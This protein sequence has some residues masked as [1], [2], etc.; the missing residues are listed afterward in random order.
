MSVRVMT[1]VWDTPLP[2]SDK[3]VLLALADCANDEGGA[4]PSMATL[5]KKCSKSDRTIQASIKRLCEA[6]HLT[7]IERPGK[8]CN[9]TVHPRS[10]FTPEAASP[11]KGATQ[12]PEAASDKPSRITIPQKATP[13][14]VARVSR[15]D[16]QSIVD[17]WNA[18][19]KPLRLPLASKL[20]A[21][22]RGRLQARIA[23]HGRDA[24]TEA[25]QR[26]ADSPHC[27]GENDRGWRAGFDFLLQPSSFLK[28]IEGNYDERK[29]SRQS[30]S[31]Y[32]PGQFR[33]PVLA[34]I[35]AMAGRQ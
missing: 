13:S 18:M 30:T 2:D 21:E 26:I 22:R 9:Y 1:R 34:D 6:G 35:A 19:A 17:E 4:W 27:R 23:E 5:V 3:I 33:D 15:D 11:P 20:T 12:T 10:D 8:G 31:R 7:R 24:F 14:S 32:A 25:I 29:P 28:V 16:C